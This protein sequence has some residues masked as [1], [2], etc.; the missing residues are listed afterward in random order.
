MK[1]LLMAFAMLG[2]F[3]AMAIDAGRVDVTGTKAGITFQKGAANC[4][5]EY[6]SWLKDANQTLVTAYIEPTE[7]EYR[8]MEFTITPDKSGIVEISVKGQWDA[9]VNNRQFYLFRKVTVNDD[10]LKNPD[11][12]QKNADG[13]AAAWWYDK[14]V[15]VDDSGAPAIKVN[16]DN[17]AVNWFNVEAGKEYKVK[18]EFKR[19]Q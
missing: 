11:F 10:L 13:K 1:Q 14:A 7:N 6:A 16:H 5:V 4:N 17:A 19:A 12:S 2:A 15:L 9:D 3:S 8:V 18:A